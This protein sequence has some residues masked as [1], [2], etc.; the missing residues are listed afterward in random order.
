MLNTP[1]YRH[2]MRRLSKSSM[3][4]DDI[5]NSHCGFKGKMLNTIIYDD[6]VDFMGYTRGII[7]T[8]AVNIYPEK[9]GKY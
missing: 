9:G 1:S 3:N 7:Q 8:F 2:M 5:Q 4:P 6:H